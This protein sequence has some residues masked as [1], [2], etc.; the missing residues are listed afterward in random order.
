M[1][2]IPRVATAMAINPFDHFWMIGEGASQVYQSRTN[3]MVPVSDP[4]Y[5]EW[6][7]SRSPTP[8]PSEADLA[9]VLQKYPLVRPWLFNAASF[10]QPAPDSYTP[11][12]LKAYSDDAR[13]RKEQGGLVTSA[14]FPIKTD[15]RAQ[16]KITGVF[17][18]AQVEPTV[19]TPWH[20]ADGTII[21]L[22]AAGMQA[23]NDDLL[24][25]INNCFSISS[26]N[27][28]AIDAG[29]MTTLEE[30]DAAYAAPITAAR[31]NWLKPTR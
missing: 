27:R 26:D 4:A 13:W 19:V 17:S 6:S 16:A 21:D 23:M 14:G 10:I 18:A 28:A 9:E 20:C 3:T 11:S 12:Q 7:L 25:H 30:I 1:S 2:D 29:T 24:T 22:D 31:A 15:D 5:V 8:I